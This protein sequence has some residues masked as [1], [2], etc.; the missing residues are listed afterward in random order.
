MIIAKVKGCRIDRA[1][2]EDAQNEADDHT[3]YNFVGMMLLQ[4]LWV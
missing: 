3:K 1:I 4:T 2:G